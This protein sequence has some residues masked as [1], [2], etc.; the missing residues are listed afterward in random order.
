MRVKDI[1]INIFQCENPAV[2][3]RFAGVFHVNQQGVLIVAK[4]QVPGNTAITA[5]LVFTDSVAG[6]V[7]GPVGIISSSDPAVVPSLSADG[8]AVN[9]TSPASG[10]VT[11]TWHDPAGVVAAFDLDIEVAAVAPSTITGAFGPF[12]PGTT[13]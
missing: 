13:P 11:V 7:K 3:G 12:V 6:T 10:V 1:V 8:Q 5:P 4:Q 2:A 9:V